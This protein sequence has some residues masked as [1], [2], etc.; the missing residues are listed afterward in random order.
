MILKPAGLPAGVNG[1]LALAHRVRTKRV[2]VFITD[3]LLQI[4]YYRFF[5]EALY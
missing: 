4:F 5:M 3:L 1:M 2:K